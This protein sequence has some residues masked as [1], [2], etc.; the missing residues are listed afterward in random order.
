MR[1]KSSSRTPDLLCSDCEGPQLL[2]ILL[3]SGFGAKCGAPHFAPLLPNTR[4]LHYFCGQSSAFDFVALF[5]NGN[6][7]PDEDWALALAREAVIRPLADR[8]INRK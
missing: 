1:S 3:Y 4:L 7:P 2:R 6:L 5:P 8:P